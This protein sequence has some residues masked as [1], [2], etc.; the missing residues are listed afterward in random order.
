MFA[1]NCVFS[2]CVEKNCDALL[3]SSVCYQNKNRGIFF[4][5]YFKATDS[6][7]PEFAVLKRSIRKLENSLL[8]RKW[9][10]EHL[11]THKYFRPFQPAASNS[12]PQADSDPDSGLNHNKSAALDGLDMTLTKPLP[13]TGSLI[14]YDKGKKSALFGANLQCMTH[15]SISSSLSF[16]H[17]QLFLLDMQ[18]KVKMSM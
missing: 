7:G 13:P 11:Q 18:H 3:A 12:K 14:V 15:F 9:Q 5:P 16:A 1:L 10:V 6:C 2:R 17:A 8:I 4:L